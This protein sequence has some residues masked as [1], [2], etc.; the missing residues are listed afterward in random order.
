MP[1]SLH[2]T[3]ID[4]FR[5][6]LRLVADLAAPFLAPVAG[7]IGGLQPL[8]TALTDPRPIERRADLGVVPDRGPVFILEVQLRIDPDKLWTWPSY[9]V[10]TRDR[11]RREVVLVVLTLSPRVAVWAKE[12]ISLGP[13]GSVL[14]PLVIGPANIPLLT[15]PSEALAHPER[16][17]LSALVHGTG[18]AGAAIAAAAAG[19]VA[20]LDDDRAR[21]YTD[22][23]LNALGE[24]A[25]AALEAALLQNYE[26]K[27]DF[28]KKY[29]AMG[30]AEGEAKGKAEGK[31]E[32]LA[33]AL[34]KVLRSRG[35]HPDAAAVV[36]IESTEETSVLFAW[37]D[38][39]LTASSVE[40]VLAD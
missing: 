10:I 7:G 1:S 28:A 31:A 8:D 33:Q 21:P 40:E 29:I 16:L 24:S 25:R 17:V 19:V 4:L 5:A 38:R 37:L 18:P 13:T 12:P 34:I 39:A 6:D 20:Q 3:L 15:D 11:L 26:Y 9:T 36:R 23:I 30:K 14:V 32:G 35:L 27:S 22:L 2:E